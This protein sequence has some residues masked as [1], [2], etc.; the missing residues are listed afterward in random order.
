MALEIDKQRRKGERERP[1]I[2]LKTQRS[3]PAD[4]LVHQS[5][6]PTIDRQW[7]NPAQMS[8]WKKKKI[9]KNAYKLIS[10]WTGKK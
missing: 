1:N 5:T 4:K 7:E 9:R 6:T 2:F 3:T 10:S 8:W